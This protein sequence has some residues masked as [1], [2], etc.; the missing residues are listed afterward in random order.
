M[1]VT[2]D[3]LSVKCSSVSYLVRKVSTFKDSRR[4]LKP[5]TEQH[6]PTVYFR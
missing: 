3:G 4:Q 6:K 1:S 5:K 2:T